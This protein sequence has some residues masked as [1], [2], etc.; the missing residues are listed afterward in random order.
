MSEAQRWVAWKYFWKEKERKYAKIPINPR[1]GQPADVS[2]AETWGTAA[3]AIACVKKRASLAG[4][5]IVLIEGDDLNGIDLDDCITDSGSFSPLAAEVIEDCET[6]FEESPSGTGVRGFTIGGIKKALAGGG[7]ELY[8]QV[9]FMT[10][11]GCHIE[12]TPLE[13]KPAPRTVAKLTSVAEAARAEKRAKTNGATNGGNGHAHHTRTVGDDFFANVNAVA[14]TKLDKWVTVLHPTAKKKPNG[15]W[16][17]PASDLGRPDLQEDLSYHPSGISY[18]G[19]EI[20]FTA[21]D[22][23]MRFGGAAEAKAAAFWLCRQMG[24]EPA[25]LG[26]RGRTK[27][28]APAIKSTEIQGDFLLVR[29]PTEGRGPGVYINGAKPSD[30]GETPPPEW[31]WLCS[32]IEPLAKTRGSDNRNW[33]RL[34]EVV[35]SDGVPHVWA[36]PAR[37][38]PTVGDGIDFRREL[39]DRGLE[40]A[41]GNNARNRLNDYITIWKPSRKVRC[42]STVGWSGDAFVMPH[43]QFGGNEEIV[44][45]VEG[46]AP[47]FTSSGTLD[48]WRCDIAARCGGNSRLMFGVSAAFAGPLLRLAGEESG[49]IHFCGSSS[50]GK[51]TMLHVARSVWGMPLGSWRTTDNSAEAIAAGACDT[52]LPLDEIS[53][54]HPRVVGELAYMLGNE[55]G[56]SRMNRN[57]TLRQTL[58]WRVLFL[59]TGEVGMA[60]RLLEGGG[61]ARAGQEV[62][63]LEIPAD[64]GKSL[65]VFEELHGF[66]NAA[67]LA[68]H[69]RLAAD[70]DCGHAARAFLERIV[71]NIHRLTGQL[72]QERAHFVADHCPPGA[73]GQVRRACG[74]FAVIAIA[75]ELATLFGITGWNVGDAEEVV[76]RCWN[77]WLVARGGAGAAEEREALDQVRLFLEQHGEARFSLAWDQENDRPVS[78]RAGFRKASEGGTTYYVLPGVFRKEVCKGF[79][80]ST[81][82][83][84][85]AARGWLLTEAKR[86]NKVERIP[87]QGSLRV[88][89]IPPDFLRGNINSDGNTGNDGNTP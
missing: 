81:I 24:I 54:A 33:G 44:L 11:T 18:F 36:M 88:Y 53:Q 63:V 2:D 43:R 22:A 45:Q 83:R 26:W 77:D 74:R 49:G 39:V 3:E 60:T 8:C 27:D 62:R 29:T 32:L 50:I 58:R 56:K 35:D 6:Y 7:V 21:V 10:V 37:I 40:I 47:E 86:P 13:V 30:D 9:R 34:L 16:R 17:I 61:K 66:G 52:F 1:T 31:R 46:V 23:V 25:T 70:R 65:G 28:G 67:E 87:G 59:S 69:L 75:G 15:A 84:A 14:L 57:A 85:M 72:T 80:P 5:G 48:N 76:V 64:A 4:V 51:T 41:S 89:V 20:S 42:V 38:G 78:N 71:E 73:D 79:D 82:A 19:E 68:E 12:G 55:R